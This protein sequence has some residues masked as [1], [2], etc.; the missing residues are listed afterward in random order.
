MEETLNGLHLFQ[1]LFQNKNGFAV[2]ATA[3]I[4]SLIL[5]AVSVFAQ[6]GAMSPYQDEQ[7]GVSIGGNWMAFR[8]EEFGSIA[9]AAPMERT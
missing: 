8:S 4:M 5:T 6:Q 1:N 7:D 3:V 9:W 2:S